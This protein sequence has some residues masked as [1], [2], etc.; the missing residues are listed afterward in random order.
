MFAVRPI[1]IQDSIFKM[2]SESPELSCSICSCS[3]YAK[4]NE[5]FIAMMYQSESE[6]KIKKSSLFETVAVSL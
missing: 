2:S 6:A 5:Q 4:Q 3:S 1:C